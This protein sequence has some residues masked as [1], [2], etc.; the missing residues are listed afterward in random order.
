M[1]HED[2]ELKISPIVSALSIFLCRA[3][4]VSRLETCRGAGGR[5]STD[6][7]QGTVR[8]QVSGQ[9]SLRGFLGLLARRQG[10]RIEGQVTPGSTEGR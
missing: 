2:A 9:S 5:G 10:L 7:V 3:L 4:T 6:L 1:K 8:L